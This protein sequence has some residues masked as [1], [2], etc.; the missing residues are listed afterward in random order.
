MNRFTAIRYL[1]C[2]LGPIALAVLLA[3][4]FALPTWALVVLGLLAYVGF[5]ALIVGWVAVASRSYPP[6]E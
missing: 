6:E 4:R 1:L 5:L 3:V 2:T